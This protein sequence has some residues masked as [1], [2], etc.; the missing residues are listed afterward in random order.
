[1]AAAAALHSMRCRQGILGGLSLLARASWQNCVASA[2]QVRVSN[3]KPA[4]SAAK[5]DTGIDQR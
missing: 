4:A 5:P 2:L 1:M 3:A